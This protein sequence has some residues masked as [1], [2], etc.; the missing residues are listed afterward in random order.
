M[1]HLRLLPAASLVLAAG[2]LGT[3][4]GAVILQIDGTVVPQSVGNIAPGLA[5]GENGSPYTN[6]ATPPMQAT[7]PGARGAIDPVSEAGVV[8]EAFMIPKTNGKFNTVNFVDL[9][10]GAGYEDTFGW[11]NVGDDVTNLANLRPVLTCAGTNY[12]P[13]PAANSQR[14]VDFDAE[15]IAGRYKGGAIGFF[16]VTPEGSAA[17]DNCGDPTSAARVGRIYFTERSRNGDG[18]YVHSITYQSRRVDATGRRVNDYY[19]GFED[20]YRGGDNDFED[21]LVLVQGLVAPCVPSAEVC[22]GKDN[23]CDGLVD[24]ATTDSNADCYAE[25]NGTP[26]DPSFAGKG[27]CRLGKTVCTNGS[28][29]C[30][31]AVFPAAEVC[32]GRDNNCNGAVDDGVANLPNACGPQIGACSATTRCVGGAPRCV[33]AQ[34]PQPEVCNGLDDDCN[35]I[36]DDN[37]VDTGGRCTPSG[38]D[39]T[40]GECRAGTSA[41]VGGKLICQ[42]YRGPAAE[43]CDGK[44]NDCNG[45]VDDAPVDLAARCTPGNDVAVCRSGAET[46]V[47]GAKVCTGYLLPAPEVCNGLD[48]DCNGKVDDDPVDT[49]ALCGNN[50]GAC[51]PGTLRCVAG[52]LAC[53]GE[54]VPAKEI[55]DGLDND[56]DGLVDENDPADPLPGVGD[57]CSEASGCSGTKSCRDGALRC[58]GGSA[59]VCDGKDNDC[60][61]VIDNAVQEAGGACGKVVINPDVKQD[62]SCVVGALACLPTT[63]ND[64][65]TDK[66]QCAGEK[67]GSPETCDGVDNDCNGVVDDAVAGT[68]TDCAPEGLA[69]PVQGTCRPGRLACVDGAFACVGGIAPRAEQC[70]GKDDD[71]NGVVDDHA[72]CPSA[73]ACIEGECRQACDATRECPGGRECA[74]GYCRLVDCTDTCAAGTACDRAAGLCRAV[75]G[76]ADDDGELGGGGCA[77]PTGGARGGEGTALG[78]VALAILA[79]RRRSGR[80][81]EEVQS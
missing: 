41:C 55:C 67:A 69:L 53:V 4:A 35:G 18:H 73:S 71:C 11:Y 37:L 61:G 5:K 57:A 70:D 54:L 2:L 10:E 24:N 59:E 22:D 6:T 62:P 1:R 75:D 8:P 14:A 9:L 78:L 25:P 26:R 56:C 77:V 7:S 79:R 39:P 45:R 19:F 40:Q 81:V 20:L 49:G 23:N 50:V 21:M 51:R 72:T 76:G 66:L 28:L 38:N 33:V 44:D 68:G 58:A 42:G 34:G 36:A 31:G 43:V 16:L 13:T 17:N 52:A 32:D 64:P 60:D 47:N 30:S 29:S 3:D 15:Y 80:D 12:E 27:D 46:C 65:T 63:G 74:A 48:D